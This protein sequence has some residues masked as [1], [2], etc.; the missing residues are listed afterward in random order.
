[1]EILRVQNA[2]GLGCYRVSGWQE[3][4]HGEQRNTPSPHNDEILSPIFNDC[5]RF[6]SAELQKYFFGFENQEAVDSWFTPTEL[7]TLRDLGFRV[8]SIHVETKD[9]IYGS[10]QLMFKREESI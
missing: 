5:R 7:D 3:A 10:K 8:N 9:I 1:M 6:S 2:E 4:E